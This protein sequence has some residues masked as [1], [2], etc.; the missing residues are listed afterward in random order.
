M[1]FTVMAM[2]RVWGMMEILA[3]LCFLGI[4]YIKEMG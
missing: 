1:R 2:G 3:S 4:Y